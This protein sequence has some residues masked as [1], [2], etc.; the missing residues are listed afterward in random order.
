MGLEDV[1]QDAPVWDT[2]SEESDLG[3][4]KKDRVHVRDWGDETRTSRTFEKHG[5]TPP[6]RTFSPTSSR[7]ASSHLSSV[8]E[9]GAIAFVRPSLIRDV[10]GSS[11]VNGNKTIDFSVLSVA[12]SDRES[13]ILRASAQ[14]GST[15]LLED[16]SRPL[17]LAP[18]RLLDVENGK[19]VILTRAKFV[20]QDG[21]NEAVV[22]AAKSLP[23][24]SEV[25]SVF[26]KACGQSLQDKMSSGSIV[27]FHSNDEVGVIGGFWR[28]ILK[29]LILQSYD[30]VNA[31]L[32]TRQ[33]QL[34]MP[35]QTGYESYVLGQIIEAFD[36]GRKKDIEYTLHVAFQNRNTSRI[37]A[38]LV[39]PR[40]DFLWHWSTMIR[41]NRRFDA[42]GQ[43]VGITS[44]PPTENFLNTR[45]HALTS[46]LR[47]ILGKGKW[48]TRVITGREG[49]IT[50]D[51]NAVAQNLAAGTCS[52]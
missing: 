21:E 8:S 34:F 9:H 46:M 43:I 33:L 22:V 1:F 3:D 36:S 2:D 35:F 52:G 37:L 42:F 4:P 6:A 11:F 39:G 40:Y 12:G 10:L 24:M 25:D 19:S 26:F 41:W 45:N 27:D 49:L 28:G 48:L 32:L 51:P 47:V 29:R 13:K 50:D 14:V 23:P 31:L 16:S 5:T 15:I 30:E 38:Q 44:F 18:R 20:H 17:N 7:A